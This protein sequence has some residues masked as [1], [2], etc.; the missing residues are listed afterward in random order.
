MSADV[1]S[2]EDLDDAAFRAL[3]EPLASEVL[4]GR[5]APPV[6]GRSGP[7]PRKPADLPGHPS[8]MAAG[9]AIPD[10]SGL[11]DPAPADSPSAELT[12]E[13]AAVVT[14]GEPG[15]KSISEANQGLSAKV[16]GN[17]AGLPLTGELEPRAQEM[18]PESESLPRAPMP[19]VAIPALP[20][21][22]PNDWSLLTPT[23]P[24]Q[25]VPAS[26]EDW[27]APPADP[28][29]SP[30]QAESE[31]QAGDGFRSSP[32]QIASF[33]SAVLSDASW[34][35]AVAAAP[36][37]SDRQQ[38]PRARVPALGTPSPVH[39][40]FPLAEQRA[41][42][43][44]PNALPEGATRA[45][46]G[47]RL[48]A[49]AGTVREAAAR[50]AGATQLVMQRPVLPPARVRWRVVALAGLV[51]AVTAAGLSWLFDS[52]SPI[53]RP[54]QSGPAI[55][56]DAGNTAPTVVSNPAS[57]VRSVL[58]LAATFA[59]R[60][61]SSPSPTTPAPQM[62]AQGGT[63]QSA[64]SQSMIGLLTQRGDAALAVGDIIA[65]RLL[66]ERA[67]T[68]GSATAAIA[69]GKTYDLD[70]LVRADTHG[71]RPDAAAAATWYRKAVALGDP[72]ARTLLARLGLQSRP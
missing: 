45:T 43:S 47:P 29:A 39:R 59:P 13:T 32:G 48:I 12:A 56:A 28:P 27:W 6:V 63:A 24:H 18:P 15:C 10:V 66:Y 54:G 4:P 53:E 50:P 70:F 33:A 46:A 35:L 26:P 5:S 19:P 58:A 38:P 41:Y 68:M 65:A 49:R 17:A 23:S 3:L 40:T 16:P 44:R 9:P 42:R 71:I 62:Q 34:R 64:A 2:Q 52:R 57:V 72:S 21:V 20:E 69:A 61:G 22:R 7:G 51:S 31:P 14:E 36:D 1:T 30:E 55:H 67:A 60:P 37:G 8:P 25:N 11:A